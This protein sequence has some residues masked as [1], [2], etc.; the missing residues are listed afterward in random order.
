MTAE[1]N[2]AKLRLPTF[3]SKHTSIWFRRAEA[4]FKNAGITSEE[5]RANCVLE[6][7]PE[8]VLET[9][10]PWLDMQPGVLKYSKLKEWILKFFS[11][12]TQ[13]KLDRLLSFPAQ[14]EQQ[15]LS[16]HHKFGT[17]ST[18]SLPFQ[19]ERRSTTRLNCGGDAFHRPAVRT[20]TTSSM[21]H[22]GRSEDQ[23][24]QADQHAAI[25]VTNPTTDA[26]WSSNV[27]PVHHQQPSDKTTINNPHN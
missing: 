9:I 16:R 3:S 19:T 21:A 5:T 20:N 4:S 12:A 1:V 13:Q 27:R 24:D 25:L 11:L 10:A 23:P 26:V 17:R 14:L 8:A 2:L 15:T 18:A 22:H 6:I 7:I